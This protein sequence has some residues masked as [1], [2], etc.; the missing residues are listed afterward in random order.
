MNTFSQQIF[1][2]S[3]PVSTSQVSHYEGC[4][5]YNHVTPESLMCW[6]V[7]N[8]LLMDFLKSVFISIICT[9]ITI[10]GITM[11]KYYLVNNVYN[12]F[13]GT[14]EEIKSRLIRNTCKID[15]HKRNIIAVGC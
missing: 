3:L 11:L 6:P 8:W 2:H 14:L 13:F 15:S 12:D 7:I 1:R 5:G 4:L 10:G 9:L